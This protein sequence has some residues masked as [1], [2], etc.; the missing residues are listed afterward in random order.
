VQ[1]VEMIAEGDC[2]H[3][4][5]RSH[6]IA[7]RLDEYRTRLLEEKALK[8]GTSPGDCARRAVTAALNG[9]SEAEQFY[10]KMSVR[11]AQM[12][13]RLMDLCDEFH[14]AIQPRFR[15]ATYRRRFYRREREWLRLSAENVRESLLEEPENP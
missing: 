3:M 9:V 12:E 8:N 10:E 11:L 4:S 6:T 15:P 1:F 5:A 14:E 2:L 7:F 13:R